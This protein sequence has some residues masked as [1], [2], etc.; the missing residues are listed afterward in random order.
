VNGRK[1]STWAWITVHLAYPLLP[2]PLEGFI[3]FAAANWTLGYDTFSAS[4]LAIS[5]GLLS[6]FVN[7][8]L[9]GQE[10]ILPDREDIDTRN[11]A[12][13]FF[14]ISGIVFFVLFGVVVLM[15]TL[16]TDRQLVVLTPLLHVFESVVFIFWVVPVA[17]AVVTQRTFKLRASFI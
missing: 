11:G 12:C 8:S 3:R 17:S 9:R 10:D 4:T 13:A 15:Y 7:Q 1:P 14:M 2:V 6:V 5:A 16:V